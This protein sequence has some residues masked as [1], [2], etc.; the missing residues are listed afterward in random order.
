MMDILVILLLSFTDFLSM[1]C[2][3]LCKL[4]TICWTLFCSKWMFYPQNKHSE[5]LLFPLV[6]LC[7]C[8]MLLTVVEFSVDPCAVADSMARQGSGLLTL[9]HKSINFSRKP[10]SPETL[11]V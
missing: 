7:F 1:F 9:I 6:F 4:F 8:L 2:T 11:V 10:E 3:T 5:V